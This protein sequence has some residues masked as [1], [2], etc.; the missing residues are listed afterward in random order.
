M[1]SM[2]YLD[3]QATTRLDPLV[4]EAMLPFLKDDYANAS[5]ASHDAGL[6][7]AEAVEKARC[8][9]ARLIGA[10]PSEVFFT[11]G[12]TE[13]NN[14]VLKGL[15]ECRRAERSHIITQ[16]TEHSSVLA[17]ARFLENHGVR[18]T[19]LPVDGEGRVNPGDV[20][21]AITDETFLISIMLANNEVGTIQPASEI[22][23]IA[24]QAGVFFH[25]DASQAAG[26]IPLN[27]QELQADLLS[28]TAHKMY[29][30]KG[31]GALYV[32]REK[33]HVRLQPLLHGGEQ[34][35][36]L[37]SGTLNV[38]GIVGFGKASEIAEAVLEDEQ[39]RVRSLREKL[40][41]GLCERL[42]FTRL[43][44]HSTH[45]LPG[46]L[47]LSFAGIE[48]EAVLDEIRG[49][50]ALSASSACSSGS[51]GASHVLQAMNVPSGYLHQA[52][53]FGIGRFTTAEEIDAVLERLTE[54]IARQRKSSPFYPPDAAL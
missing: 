32:R 44:G 40:F 21:S 33:P 37:R 28:W 6:R 3:N 38:P 53:R 43:N 24:K 50:I 9:T 46:N 23:R 41:K 36:G 2:I 45:R 5:S 31:I 8:Q 48:A 15:W 20:H 42:D 52:L 10:Q 30:P 54:V 27:V 39:R 26:K 22:G 25:A 13:S 12:A 51:G 7:A 4:L 35:R 16:A 49:E 47:N 29:G 19:V 14:T 18:L 1:N 34:E 17:A 11:S